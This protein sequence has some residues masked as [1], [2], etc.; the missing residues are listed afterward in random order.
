[1]LYGM[2]DR[3]LKDLGLTR[4]EIGSALT[5]VSGERIRTRLMI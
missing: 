2:G 1:M 5:D 3:E 4:S